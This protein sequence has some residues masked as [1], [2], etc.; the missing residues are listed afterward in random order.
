MT[1]LLR[2]SYNNYN[3]FYPTFLCT[4][5]NYLFRINSLKLSIYRVENIAVS[6]QVE[7][8]KV[9]IFYAHLTF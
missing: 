5:A 2:V 9:C 6:G 4:Q 8:E 3:F 1:K 7:A